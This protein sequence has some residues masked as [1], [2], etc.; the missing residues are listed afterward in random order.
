MSPRDSLTVL[1]TWQLASPRQRPQALLWRNLRSQTPSLPLYLAG[2]PSISVGKDQ[3]RQEVVNWGHLGGWP[4]TTPLSYPISKSSGSRC[5]MCLH[6]GGSAYLRHWE[7]WLQSKG[8]GTQPQAILCLDGTQRAAWSKEFSDSDFPSKCHWHQA[9][10]ETGTSTWNRSRSKYFYGLGKGE[11]EF[12][13][14]CT[15]ELVK[16]SYFYCFTTDRTTRRREDSCLHRTFLVVLTQA[17]LSPTDSFSTCYFYCTIN[18]LIHIIWLSLMSNSVLYYTLW[19]QL[20]CSLNPLQY[21]VNSFKSGTFSL[22]LGSASVSTNRSP[23]MCVS[24][25][26]HTHAFTHTHNHTHPYNQ[27]GGRWRARLIDRFLQK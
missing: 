7:F 27:R 16:E 23:G 21:V 14:N 11:L 4:H 20:H 17:Y 1:R 13:Q 18:F 2:Y 15:V 25:S 12:P 6:K 10:L 19:E 3:T 22:L 8:P 24:P 26:T 9:R 5:E